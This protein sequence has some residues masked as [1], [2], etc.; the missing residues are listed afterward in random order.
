MALEIY[1]I[2]GY[3]PE[4]VMTG[5]TADIRTIVSN[6]WYDWIKLYDLVSNSFP[7]DK[8]YLGLYLGPATDIGPSLTAKILKMI[9]E[10]VYRSTYC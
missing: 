2:N 10:V 9:R 1:K 4:T 6:G 8:Y 3:V 7:E 5:D